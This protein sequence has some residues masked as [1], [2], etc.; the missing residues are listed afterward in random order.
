MAD[1]THAELLPL[2]EHLDRVM[3]CDLRARPYLLPLHAAAVAVHG[4]PLTLAAGRELARAIDD[5]H[6]PIVLIVTGFASVVLGV[7][8]QDGPPGAV[9]LGRAL[10]A[11]GALPLFV[12]DK[13]QVDLMRQASRGGGLNV[14]ELERARAAVAV[15]QS[16]SAIVDWPA[17]R[18]AARLK[19]TAL[20][21]ETSPAA[22]I[23]IERP[24]ANEHGRCH[25]LGGQELSLALCSDTDVLWNA[26][27]AAGIPSIGIGDAGNELG[28]GAIN[29]SVQREL[30]DRRCP[31]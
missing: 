13:H 28:M 17:D 12:T 2:A 21:A 23:A 11:L 1:K 18:D 29:A 16:V 20:I 9:Y 8:E 14:I 15:K 31:S 30:A 7:G 22:I 19:A 26:A 3:S 5:K 6:L 24:G 27:R 4:E 25:Q 10:A